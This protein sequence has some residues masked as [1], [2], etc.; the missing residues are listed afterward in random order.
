M[1]VGGEACPLDLF[2]RWAPGRR[3]VNA[4][5]PTEITVVASTAECHP[6]DDA[7][8]IGRPIADARLYVLDEAPGAGPRRRGRASSASAAPGSPAAT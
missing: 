8:T 7:V 3:F 5:G 4:Y 1:I 2:R 6:D